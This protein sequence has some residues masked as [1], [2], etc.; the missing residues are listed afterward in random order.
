MVYY[1]HCSNSRNAHVA[2][3][4]SRRNERG[5]KTRGYKF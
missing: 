5:L 1:S 4:F 2:A 3:G